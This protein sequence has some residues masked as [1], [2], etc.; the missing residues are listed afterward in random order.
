MHVVPKQRDQRQAAGGHHH[1]CH[2]PA[3][4]YKARLRQAGWA[5]KNE[6]WASKTIAGR[7]A[8]MLIDRAAARKERLVRCK[9]MWLS[10]AQALEAAYKR[11]SEAIRR[12][13]RLEDRN[14]SRGR[15]SNETRRTTHARNPIA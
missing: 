15:G 6:F 3:G 13:A 9:V 14:V 8:L 7:H 5:I 2:L 10:T 1:I 12:R 4:R 11:R